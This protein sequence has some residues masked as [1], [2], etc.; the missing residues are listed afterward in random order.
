[1][2]T[3]EQQRILASHGLLGCTATDFE[4][5]TYVSH[6]VV[7]LCK[8]LE[9]AV[10]RKETLKISMK[11]V[12]EAVDFVG[13]SGNII[14]TGVLQEMHFDE[15]GDPDPERLGRYGDAHIRIAVT[16]RRMF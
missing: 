8:A 4:G 6:N 3:N 13:V 2:I 1:M 16:E 10:A 11:N 15:D 7:D 14:A 9:A 12:G 5:N